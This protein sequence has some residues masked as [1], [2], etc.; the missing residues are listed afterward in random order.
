MRTE[1]IGELIE[2]RLAQVRVGHLAATEQDRQFDLVPGIQK[3]GGLPPFCLQVVVVDFGPDADLFQLDDVLVAAR[4]ALLAALLVAKL[5]VVH[6]PAHGGHR[7]GSHLDQIEATLARHLKRIEGG[8][9]ADL[10]AVLVDQPNLAD[11]DALI[12]AG[13]DGSGN[14]LPPFPIAGESLTIDNT[15]TRRGQSPARSPCR[16]DR[17]YSI[18]L[19][20]GSI[21][22][23]QF[24]RLFGSNREPQALKASASLSIVS[25]L[26]WSGDP[27]D[28]RKVPSMS[29]RF[30]TVVVHVE[31]AEWHQ[32][33]AAL[34]TARRRRKLGN[35]FV[36]HYGRCRPVVRESFFVELR[37]VPFTA[38]AR[39]IDKRT[40]PHEVIRAT[41]GDERIQ[42]EIVALLLRCPDDV[43]AKQILLV[44]SP[45]TEMKRILTLKTSLNRALSANGRIGFRLVKPCPDHHRSQG[46]VIQVADM[47]A[48]AL[49]DAGDTGS[50]Y[51]DGL[52][53]KIHI[54]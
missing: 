9:D 51:F 20:V 6:E 34:A 52:R 44:D 13:L 12:D 26:D 30:V 17:D 3:L 18:W 42:S 7:I 43:V 11:P 32:L 41:S 47:I 49:H 50:A 53:K 23:V 37:N 29:P 38:H 14:S 46:A 1:L 24:G 45:K 31:R 27:G 5:A 48:G 21:I 8:D 10:L 54:V 33:E 19:T 35:E 36:F 25:G 40:W 28:P 4:L 2:Q 39:I 15:G 16:L 22:N